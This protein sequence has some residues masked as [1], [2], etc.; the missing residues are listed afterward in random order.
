MRTL[1]AL[2]LLAPPAAAAAIPAGFTPLFN[3]KDLAGWHGYAVHD[4]GADPATLAAKP[5]ADRDAL[6][7]KWTADAVKH[8]RAEAGELVNDGAGAYLATDAAFGDYELVLEYK[9]VAK[10]DSGIYLKATPQVQIWDTTDPEKFSL[11]AAKGSGGLWNNPAG[12]PGKD[13]LVKADKPLGE[14]NAVR[15]LQLGDRVTVTLNGQ[16]VVDHARLHNYYAKGQP[17]EPTGPVVLQ[18]HGGEIRWRNLGVRV[19]PP[20]EA[21]ARL[22]GKAGPGFT[23][24]FDGKSLTGWQGATDDY[25]VVSGAIRCKP[26]RGGNL[27]TAAKYADFTLVVEYKLP[28]GGNNGLIVRYPGTGDGSVTGLGEIQVLD[29]TAPQYA[30]LDPRQYNGSLYGLIPAA[31]G[32]LRPVGEWNLMAV[33]AAGSKVEVELNGAVVTAGDAAAVTDFMDRK[34]HPGKDSPDGYLGFAGH[35]DPV[36]FRT[37][38]VKTAK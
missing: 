36:A 19:I 8:W 5:A 25:E 10:A 32:H 9:T 21:N 30:K 38:R 16:L 34:P 2:V 27:F 24:L 23:P 20:A 35:N 28:P 12:S 4:K 31:R 6:V 14:W 26:G 22:L 13:P 11:G 1:F 17:L 29:D 18:T 33:T 37:V 3:G 7:A 15:V